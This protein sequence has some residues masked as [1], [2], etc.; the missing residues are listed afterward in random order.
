[1]YMMCWKAETY[2]SPALVDAL[3]HACC[4]E[5]IGEIKAKGRRGYTQGLRS[6]APEIR[7]LTQISRERIWL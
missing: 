6:S 2:K 5:P 4:I 7:T 3:Y 1:M